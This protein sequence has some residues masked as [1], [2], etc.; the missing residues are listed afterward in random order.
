MVNLAIPYL[1][2]GG[3]GPPRVLEL[4]SHITNSILN[5]HHLLTKVA[6]T[7]NIT[8]RILVSQYYI[9]S[10]LVKY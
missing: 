2:E 8:S 4:V 5:I 10:I 3:V 1:V 6:Q 7:N 9:K